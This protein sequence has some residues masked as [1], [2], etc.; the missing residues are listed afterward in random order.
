VRDP[1]ILLPILKTSKTVKSM[2]KHVWSHNLLLK[3]MTISAFQLVL[4]GIFTSVAC[5][6][7]G[8]AQQVLNQRITLEVRQE[9][10]SAVLKK[11]SRQTGVRF[12]YSSELIQGTRK[13]TLKA[14][15]EPL[16]TV[17]NTLLVPLKIDYEV[18]DRQ[19]LLRRAPENTL[20]Q[21]VRTPAFESVVQRDVT[22]TVTDETGQPLPGVSVVVSGTTRGT[23]TDGKG[24]Y[25]L[26]VP[27][28]NVVLIFSYVGYLPKEVTL[29]AQTLF[30]VTLTPDERGL[31]EVQVVAFGEQRKRDLTGSISSIKADALKTNSAASPDVALQGRA[32][33]VQIT[34]AGGTPGGAVRINVRGVASINSNAQPLIVIDGVP[35]LSSAFGSGGVA[36]NPLSEINPDDIESMEVLKDA[37]ASV[38]YGSRAANGVILITTKKGKTGKPTFDVSYQ[39]GITDATNRV[40]LV[41]NGADYFAI[42]KRAAAQNK[43]TGLT[44]ASTNLVSLL[45]AGIL[46]GSDANIDARLL[47][48]SATL[49][50]TRTDWLSQVLRQGSFRVATLGVSAGSKTVSA[51]LSGSYR[52][53][54]GIVIGQSLQRVSGRLNLTYKPIQR[55]QLGLNTSI[56]GLVN[57]AL[58][59]DNSFR[60]ALTT[61]LPA[62]PVQ[63]AD[64]TYFNGINRGSN[65]INIGSN[66]VFYRAN[67]SDVTYTTRSI[68][69]AFLQIEPVTGLSIRTEWGYDFQKSTND[70]LQTTA[71]FP[72]GIASKEKN[73]NGRAQNRDATNSTW[74]TNNLITYTRELFKSHRLTVLLGNSVQSQTSKSNTYITENVANGQRG[75]TDTVRVVRTND[76]PAFRFVSFFG[77]LNYMIRDKY[78]F[79]ATFRTDGSSRF[80]PG[81]KYASFPGVSAGWVLSEEPFIRDNLIDLSFLKVRASYGLTGNAEI[82]NFSW[83]KSFTYVGYNAAIYGGVQGGQFTNP[84]NQDLSWESTKQLNIGLDAGL[85]GNRIRVTFDFYNKVSNGLLLD[86]SLGPLYGTINNVMTI[87]LGSVR[88]RG[89]ELSISTQNL[90]RPRFRWTT[91]FNIARN[92]NEVVSTYTAPF[93]NYP[94]QFITGPSIA[95]VGYPLGTYYLPVFAGFDPATGNELFYERDR[96]VFIISGQT[97]R[98]GNF[99]DGTVNNQSGN[100][101]FIQDGK[102]PYPTFFGGLTNTFTIGRFD[103][104]ALIYFQYGNWIYDQGE[105]QQSYPV[106]GQVLRAEVPGIGNLANEARR[107]DGGAYRLQWLSNARGFES[108]R[109]LHDGSYTRLKNLQVGYTLPLTTAKRLH[110]RTLRIYATAQ[111]LLTLTRFKGWDPEIFAN[112]GSS[113]AGAAN[114][115][116]GVTNNDLPQIKT[117]SLGLNVGF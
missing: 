46:Q 4:L 47:A 8:H 93:L 85:L 52:K 48:D 115:S 21:P 11:I 18:L 1:G 89:E 88:N 109:F 2:Q 22:G 64:G 3:I 75:G 81:R 24:Q 30:D 107:T 91:D 38:L 6:F 12:M 111:N 112:N 59:L 106:A 71:L 10:I 14:T 74:N 37:A 51:Y 7:D 58:P 27:D 42:L 105:R 49:Y 26:T 9:P 84:G 96:N 78:L 68:N 5:A 60:Y 72:T 77:R 108:T 34:Q 62:Y 69:T 92:K 114:I 36:M 66:P 13:V 104:S 117:V 50:N 23:T 63:L 73:G 99:W 95:A 19:I 70:I 45:P 33:G 67:Y 15:D 41:E 56:N 20:I 113:N 25:Q 82:G 65:A 116:P 97:V 94:Y 57:N 39:E 61:A 90:V 87:N 79:E 54:N 103:L 110:L 32:A 98:T 17:L 28:G 35:V 83:Q 16:G 43:F 31:Q 76:D 100:N 86:Y 53:D 80:G 55:L 40:K 44:P 101:Q 102:T 29:G